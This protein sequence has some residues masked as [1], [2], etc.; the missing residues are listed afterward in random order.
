VSVTASDIDQVAVRAARSNAR[1]N[2]ARP[3]LAVVRAAGLVAPQLRAQQPYELIL[4]NI[5]LAPLKRLARPLRRA[6]APGGR[7]VLSGLLAPQANAALSA[8]RLQGLRLERRIT[9]D[10][11]TTLVMRNGGTLKHDPEKAGRGP[12][13]GWVPVFRKDHALPGRRHARVSARTAADLRC[14]DRADR[15]RARTR[16]A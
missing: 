2:R 16:P 4:A 1:L 15:R 3:R 8:Y 6:L 10:N 14:A 11:W 9:L 13:P 5:L 12:D 7:I